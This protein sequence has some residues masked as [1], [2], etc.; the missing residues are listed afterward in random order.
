MCRTDTIRTTR[1]VLGALGGLTLVCGIAFGQ[2]SPQPVSAPHW[3][4]L[5]NESV[6][7]N[8]AGPVGGAAE[9][10]WFSP[11][12]DRL[13]ARNKSGQV[14]ETANFADWIVSKT[15]ANAAPDP[16]TR[17]QAPDGR[18]YLLGRDLQVSEDSGST[19]VNL[20]AFKGVSIIGPNQHSLAVSPLD[21]R[22]IVVANDLGVWRSTDAGLSWSS[23]NEELPNLPMRRLLPR[24]PSGSLRAQVEG[25]G[26]V[27]L[28]PAA[29]AAHANWIPVPPPKDPAAPQAETEAQLRAE[30]YLH[31]SLTAF[32]KSANTWFAGSND[33]RLWTSL[34]NGNSWIQSPLRAGGR[35]EVL[36]TGGDTLNDSPRSA[37]AVVTPAP[38]SPGTVARVV[39]LINAG[40]SWD[41][42][43]SGLPEGA[44]HGVAVEAGARVAYVAGD[45]GIFMAHVDLN[46]LEPVTTWEPVAG[47]PEA[48]AMD[49]R[50]DSVR[51]TL[52]AALDGYG[53]Y[54]APS[55][56]KPA[57][58]RV[59]T[60]ADQ[61]AL[62]AAPGLLLHVQGS[63]LSQIRADGGEL[64]MVS[65]SPVSAQ[66]QVPFEAT[67]S[68]LAL[69]V[70]SSLGQSRVAL[71]LQQVAPS[72]LVDGD[73]LPILVDAA[74]NLTLDARN[75]AHPG[76][77]IQ[78]FASG[79]GKVN[80]EWRTG[81]PA[82]EDPPAVLARVEASLNGAPLEVT[83]ATLAPGYVG[84]YLV[85]V[86]LPGLLDAG[87][88]DFSLRVSGEDSNHVKILIAVD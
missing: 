20:T 88:G 35:I 64:A 42:V 40:S 50:L 14:F 86:Q 58:V 59:L 13:Y 46:S 44:I 56:H 30:Q 24:A 75:M 16:A 62:A 51:N 18:T 26:E 85:E 74:S 69:T 3:R 66:V 1:K 72:I 67:G 55:P 78:V 21:S 83:R 68:T 63:G 41:D 71:P 34:D 10:V 60:A 19:F 25:I 54:A 79:L 29:A 36:Q 80:P 53:L 4:K 87:A 27:E 84:L 6:G 12:G 70:D 65:S 17:V 43:S 8:L 61:P 48:R 47:L 57:A 9:A 31:T 49:V 76:A 37:L 2:V 33:G 39:R 82:P 7:L 22:Q 5:G 52:Y 15:P 11:A 38:G 23:L 81:I 32:A 73:G 28:P 77:R 45:R